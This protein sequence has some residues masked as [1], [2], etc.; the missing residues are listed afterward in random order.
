MQ[1]VLATAASYAPMSLLE[2]CGYVDRLSAQK[3]F[4]S[5]ATLL[6]DFRCEKSQLRL[7]QGSLILGMIAFSYSLDKD[8]RYWFHN[9]LRLAIKM[10]LHKR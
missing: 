8:F 7:L 5:K 4:Y 10:G 1:A 6:Y 2:D 3:A 9:S